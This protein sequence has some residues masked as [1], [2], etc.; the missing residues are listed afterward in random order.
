[1]DEKINYKEII[2]KY[3]WILKRNQK[4][5]LS[6]DSDGLLCGLFM[7]NILN[8]SIT[9]FY[10][11]KVLI[12]KKGESVKDCIFLDME[13]FREYVKS[14]G[15]HMVLYNKRHKPENW[16]NFSNCIQPN[17]IRGYDAKTTFN[18]KY[19]LGAIH[20]ILGIVGYKRKV[21]IKK[22]AICP[23]LYTDGTFKNLFNYPDNCLSWLNFLYAEEKNS[24]LNTIFFNDHYS[25]S[26]L[27]I[28]LKDFFERIRTITDGSRGGDKIKISSPN[29]EPIN[30]IKQN[31]SFSLSDKSKENAIKFLNI[32]AELTGWR[33]ISK[34]WVFNNFYIYKFKKGNINPSNQRFNDLMKK[35]PLSWAM[36]STLAIEYTLEEPDKLP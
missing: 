13:I 9:G 32:L 19:P 4:C 16:F 35:N 30:L 33:F 27:M 3:P 1:M 21:E 24:P 23:L 34:N 2:K 14:L 10:D 29:G 7:S 26:S 22:T 8:W 28:A 11:G 12:L 31:N 20:L 25:T 6:P 15:H 17:N 5:I 18:L 36:T